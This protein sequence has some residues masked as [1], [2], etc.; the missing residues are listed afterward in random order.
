MKRTTSPR[1]RMGVLL[2]I[3][4]PLALLGSLLFVAQVAAVVETVRD[5]FQAHSYAA[6]NGTQNWTSDW[7]ETNDDGTATNGNIRIIPPSPGAP[8]NLLLEGFGG[9]PIRSI[10]RGL[11]LTGAVT[12]TLTF[13]W[14]CGGDTETNDFIR[15]QTSANGGSSYSTIDTLTGGAGGWCGSGGSTSGSESYDVSAL[16]DGDP[17]N[18]RIRFE[19]EVSATNEDFRI[20]FVQVA[21]EVPDSDTIDGTVFRDYDNDGAIDSLEPGVPDITITAYLADGSV[22]DTATTDANG[23]YALT[24]ANGTAVRLEVSGLPDYLFPG[25]AG[26]DSATNVAFAT[27]DA[28]VNFGLVNPDQYCDSTELAT[29]CYVNNAAANEVGGFNDVLVRWDYTLRGQATSPTHIAERSDMGSVWGLAFDRINGDLYTSAFM[30]RYVGLTDGL[31][32]IFLSDP[33]LPPP[34]GTV[35]VD[36]AAAPFNMDLG[37]I[38]DDTARGLPLD[39]TVQTNDPTTFYAVGKIGMGDLDISED[40]DTL[41]FTNLFDQTV[42]SLEIDSDGDPGTTPGLADLSSFP[43]PTSQCNS[44]GTLQINS[45][46]TQHTSLVAGYDGDAYYIGGASGTAGGSSGAPFSTH[47]TDGTSFDYIVPMPDG[48]YTVTLSFYDTTAHTFDVTIEGVTGNVVLPANTEQTDVRSVTVTDGMMDFVFD[49]GT[50]D[51]PIVSGIQIVA[52]SGT[53]FNETHPFGLAIHDEDVYVGVICTAEYTQDD[54]EL[55]AY[56]FRL[57]NSTLPWVQVV[58]FDLDYTKGAASTSGTCGGATSAWHPWATSLAAACSGSN[59]TVRPQPQLSAIVFDTDDSIIVSLMDRLGHQLGNQNW[60]PAGTTVREGVIGGDLLRLYNNAGTY[61][62][63]S[64]GSVGPLTAAWLTSDNGVGNGQGVGGGE[65]YQDDANPPRSHQETP[66]GAVIHWYGQGEVGATTMDPLGDPVS[67]GVLFFDNVTGGS[68]TGAADDSFDGF[69]VY[70]SDDGG[71]PTTFGKSNGLGDLELLCSAAPIEIGNR[72]WNDVDGDGVQDA[73]ELPVAGVT[74]RLYRTDGTLIGN[75]VTDANGQYLF[76]STTVTTGTIGLNT[77][78][79]IRIDDLT[80]ITGAGLSALSPANQDQPQR[81]SDGSMTNILGLAN[82]NRPEVQISTGRDG[83]NDHTYDF[84]FNAVPTAVSLADFTANLAGF[85]VQLA[86]L[87]GVL[88]LL[89]AVSLLTRQRRREV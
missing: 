63:E 37:E 64:N 28:T 75:A 30:K 51:D 60:E 27:S 53:P 25:P 18:S 15:I 61:E 31:G 58:T 39:A 82:G 65:F 40:Y 85:P 26:T 6:Q 23:N 62:L 83:E 68:T 87:L 89:T 81:D 14:T 48:D 7:V 44:Y 17:S 79:I 32:A 88:L 54:T 8:Q 19:H 1:K 20:D 24:V 56:I 84:G 72:V 78:Y 16:I 3:A 66:T 41:W 73:G 21:F 52:D 76:N 29:S 55:D 74:V 57:D 50:V 71:P 86:L 49:N 33:T 70:Q 46:G 80:P 67:G 12:A 34:N 77:D 35:W 22:V 11:D 5:D 4:L 43:V 2:A 42:Y 13:D 36:L 45:S 47:R 10:D 9:S 59:R 38:G 69:E